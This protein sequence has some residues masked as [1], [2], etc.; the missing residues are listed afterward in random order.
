M[1]TADEAAWM[2]QFES[3]PL[4]RSPARQLAAGFTA[5]PRILAAL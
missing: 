1:P 3:T 2:R 4:Y 5:R